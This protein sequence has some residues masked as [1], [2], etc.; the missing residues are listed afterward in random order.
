MTNDK[1]V[2]V[3]VEQLQAQRLLDKAMIDTLRI[4]VDELSVNL[5]AANDLIEGDTKATLIAELNLTTDY[6]LEELVTMG[7]DELKT[8]KSVSSRIRPERKLSAGVD[9]AA[10]GV[11]KDAWKKEIYGKFRGMVPR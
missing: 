8:V 1:P 7:V 2:G 11:D 6:K 10:L 9:M 3:S 4:Q 5:K